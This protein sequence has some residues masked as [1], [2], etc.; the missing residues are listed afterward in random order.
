[1]KQ[2]VHH[3]LPLDTREAI[4]IY[5]HNQSK[6]QAVSILDTI[7]EVRRRFPTLNSSDG[8][9]TDCIAG[10]AIVLDLSIAFDARGGGM[11][12]ASPPLTLQ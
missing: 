8:E 2:A 4:R 10:T 6:N 3:R 9:L 5:L 7:K 11:F 12:Y 1:M